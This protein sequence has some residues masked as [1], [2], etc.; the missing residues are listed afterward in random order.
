MITEQ[1][2]YFSESPKLILSKYTLSEIE[3]MFGPLDDITVAENYSLSE[4]D[5]YLDRFMENLWK[6]Y[7]RLEVISGEIF[8]YIK[9]A[10]VPKENFNLN[11][12]SIM[13]LRRL[14]KMI[15]GMPGFEK[16]DT[17]IAQKISSILHRQYVIENL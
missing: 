16:L 4:Y 5:Q 17:Q 7:G 2:L 11:S 15:S 1:D 3:S 8:D 13:A 12:Y 10:V 9:G 14:Q 6:K